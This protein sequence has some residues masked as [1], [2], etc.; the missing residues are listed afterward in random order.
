MDGVEIFKLNKKILKII[1]MIS[2]FNLKLFRLVL[3]K[4]VEI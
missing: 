4:L 2:N 1:I 3:V